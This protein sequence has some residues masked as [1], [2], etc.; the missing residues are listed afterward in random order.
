MFLI[1]SRGYQDLISIF[2]S[3]GT[4]NL[5]LNVLKVNQAFIRLWI[6]IRSLRHHDFED[7]GRTKK[8]KKLYV[9]SSV[10]VKYH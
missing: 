6:K 9:Q 8:R 3:L 5:D 10:V 1:L 7:R 2:S 4:I